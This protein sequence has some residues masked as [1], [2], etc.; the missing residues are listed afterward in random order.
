MLETVVVQLTKVERKE[1]EY[2]EFITPAKE[3]IQLESE[4]VIPKKEETNAN[5]LTN[6]IKNIT[7]QTTAASPHVTSTS[8]NVPK[9]S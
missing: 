7:S 2:L 5:G 1:H 3:S 9:Y 4:K 6:F 8:D